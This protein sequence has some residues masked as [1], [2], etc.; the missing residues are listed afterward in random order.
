MIQY[1]NEKDAFVSHF[2]HAPNRVT[3][4]KLTNNGYA[5]T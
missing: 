4:L 1:E 3:S 2:G 5:I